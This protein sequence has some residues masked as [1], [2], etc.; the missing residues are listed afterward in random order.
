MYRF[1]LK[2][3]S[4]VSSIRGESTSQAE[5][6][7]RFFAAML[8]RPASEYFGRPML[9]G[10]WVEPR[11]LIG[12]FQCP[13]WLL[14]GKVD[15][16]RRRPWDG[17]HRL[18]RTIL[19][20]GMLPNP[21]KDQRVGRLFLMVLIWVLPGFGLV[22]HLRGPEVPLYIKLGVMNDSP[23]SI[24]IRILGPDRQSN[25]TKNLFYCKFCFFWVSFL[26]WTPSWVGRW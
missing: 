22:G 7:G 2:L 17:C 20:R 13:L 24:R 11:L 6:H 19:A 23:V 21:I 10:T 3:V 18:E 16:R 25:Q 14:L 15:R 8:E 9:S 26:P 5:H 1:G 12:I 4:H